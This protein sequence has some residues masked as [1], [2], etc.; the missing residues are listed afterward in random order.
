MHAIQPE[1]LAQSALGRHGY[2][3][4]IAVQHLAL[5]G[6]EVGLEQCCFIG[7]DSLWR[8]R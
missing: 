1:P 2:K 7:L 8:G 5:Y 4:G 3:P 6:L